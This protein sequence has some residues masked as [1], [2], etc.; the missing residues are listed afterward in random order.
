[1]RMVSLVAVTGGT[2]LMLATAC[3]GNGN[4]GGSTNTGTSTGTGGGAEWSCPGS[5]AEAPNSEFCAADATTPDCSLITSRYHTQICGVAVLDPTAELA[6]SSSVKEYAGSGPP[7]LDCLDPAHY[8]TAG[9]SQ[10]VTMKG[11]VKM[12]SNGCETKNVEISIF[13]VV[14]GEKS[15]TPMGTPVV[16]PSDC[17]ADGVAS[18]DPNTCGTRYE[19]HYTYP[20]VESET[21]LVVLTKGT[22][23]APLYTYNIYVPTSEVQNG[24]WTYD[25]RALANDDYTSIP[26][27]VGTTIAPGNGALAGEVHDCGNV[28]LQNATVDIDV[29]KYQLYYFT[30][31]ETHPLPTLSSTMT[32][33]LGLYA[34]L[35]V[36]AGKARVAALGMVNGKVTTLGYHTVE[37]FPDSVTSVTIRGVR[38]YQVPGI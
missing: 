20:G 30:D 12:F 10:T 2:A 16:T 31:N 6:R 17:K 3:G 9:A 25:L 27:T 15:A 29:S 22:D 23:W 8:P 35:D 26:Q 34:A 24:E 36:P 33:V 19:C 1:M 13:K 28:R 5:L 37:V 11:L 21:E 38:P 4:N 7:Q 32:S 14:N 18:D